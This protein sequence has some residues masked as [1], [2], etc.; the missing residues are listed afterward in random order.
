MV[1]VRR[2]DQLPLDAEFGETIMEVSS[3]NTRGEKIE[4]KIDSQWVKKNY[5]VKLFFKE[6]EA[7]E[8]FKLIAPPKNKLKL[9]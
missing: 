9:A 1:L 3:F 2:K 5:Y 7:Y 8:K 4:L 6:K